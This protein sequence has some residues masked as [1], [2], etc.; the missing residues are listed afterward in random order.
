MF[1]RKPDQGS[2]ALLAAKGISANVMVAD[3]HLNIVYM[4]DAVTDLLREA[5]AELKKE[6][7][8]FNVA[9]LIGTNIDV[10]HRDP[11]HQRKVLQS[12]SSTHRA[13]IRIG[14]RA[15]DLVASPL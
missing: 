15:F 5:E 7:P 8:H 10:F 14:K 2:L 3:D 9:T 6:L 4:N 12:L 11:S 13:T 1:G